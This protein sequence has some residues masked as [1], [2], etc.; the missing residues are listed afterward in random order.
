VKFKSLLVALTVT[1]SAAMAHTMGTSAQLY[2]LQQARLHDVSSSINSLRHSISTAKANKAKL[3]N[4][5]RSSDETIGELAKS[6]NKTL[7]LLH[8]RERSL[9]KVETQHDNYVRELAKQ[10]QLLGQQLRLAY[11]LGRQQHIKILLNAENPAEIDRNLTYYRY[12][13]LSRRKTIAAMQQSLAGI[14]KTTAIVRAHTQYLETLKAEQESQRYKL[15]HEHYVRYLYLR[16]LEKSLGDQ[17]QRLNNLIHNRDHLHSVIH[18]IETE[19]YF[20]APG[21]D[22]AKAYHK[23]PWPVRHA[24]LLQTFN[25]LIANGHL[26][27]SGVLLG[28][29]DGTPIHAI[30]SGKVVFADWMRGYGLMVIVT[31]GGHFLTVYAHA[32]SLYVKAGQTVHAGQQIATVGES[33]GLTRPALYFEIRRDGKALDPIAWLRDPDLK[34]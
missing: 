21:A 18:A 29:P 6:L 10:E 15:E 32:E 17:Q 16:R 28:V 13:T 34:N 2:Q 3:E 23:L 5:L 11:M 19:K 22:F 30:F 26:R 33:G 12:L 4:D 9:T 27:S 7:R 14:A 25:Q 24:E 8:A 20:Y 1:A 31:H